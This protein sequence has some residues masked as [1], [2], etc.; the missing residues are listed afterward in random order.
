MSEGASPAFR[1]TT[2]IE[3]TE[4]A[5]RS[6]EDRRLTVAAHDAGG[7]PAFVVA[8]PC[9]RCEHHLVD[10]QVSVALTGLTGAQRQVNGAV[11]DVVVLDVTCGCGTAHQDAPEG[12]TGCGASFRI[13]LDTS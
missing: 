6:L 7:V 1:A 9:P 4:R 8:G 3:W 11:L 10:R 2:D 5:F 12:V 13:E